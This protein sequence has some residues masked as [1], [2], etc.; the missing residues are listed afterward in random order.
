MYHDI[1]VVETT[2]S[3]NSLSSGGDWMEK[4]PRERG[5]DRKEGGGTSLDRVYS[6]FD[7]GDMNVALQGSKIWFF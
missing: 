5:L 6:D 2:L 3:I 7:A 1:Y 4:Q